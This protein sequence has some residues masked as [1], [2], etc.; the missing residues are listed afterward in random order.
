[1]TATQYIASLRN[2]NQQQYA[3]AYWAWLDFCGNYPR[4]SRTMT[5]G[6]ALAIRLRLDAIYKGWQPAR[7]LRVGPTK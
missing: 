5:E 4:R 6:A 3:E 7:R 1:M 2:F